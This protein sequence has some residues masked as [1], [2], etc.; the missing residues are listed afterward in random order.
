MEDISII[1]MML[2]AALVLGCLFLILAP[3]FNWDFYLQT[4]S[5]ETNAVNDK[6]VLFTTLNELEFEYKMHKLSESDYKKLKKQYE[7]QLAKILKE[8]EGKVTKN[9]DSSIMAEVEREIQAK[10]KRSKEGAR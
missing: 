10:M 2:T 7:A 3:L 6:E 4:Q 8:D 9:V 1:S 5:N